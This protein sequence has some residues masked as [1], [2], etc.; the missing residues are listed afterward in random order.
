[1]KRC[2]TVAKPAMSNIICGVCTN[3]KT[4]FKLLQL[5]ANK[6]SATLA[7]DGVLKYETKK[8]NY[9][10]LG[11]LINNLNVNESFG[12]KFTTV[13]NTKIYEVTIKS[14]NNLEL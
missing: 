2:Y 12:V 5:A 9:F 6:S 8:F 3:R 1:M 14:Y 10:N 4:L 11:T 13:K 7:F